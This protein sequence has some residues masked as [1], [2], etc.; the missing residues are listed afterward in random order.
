MGRK[1]PGKPRRP[2]NTAS[3]KPRKYTLQELQ[4]PGSAYEEWYDVRP[5]MD[6]SR[7]ADPRLSA[8]ALDL[9]RR[10]ARLGPS[11]GGK[12]PKAALYLDSLIDDGSLPIVG[13][14][15]TGIMVPIEEM[16]AR[17]GGASRDSIR[18][19]I[20]NLHTVGALLIET[21][22]DHDISYVRM[23]AK[24]PAEPGDPWHFEGDPDVV[25]ATTCI[26]NEIWEKL[27][28]DVA[29]AVSFMRTCRSQL[30]EPDPE[31]YG[32]HKSVNGPEHARQLFAAGE[33]SGFVD[34]KGCEACPT[35][36]LCTRSEDE[37]ES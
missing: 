6:A 16:A 19:S 27:P 18:E 3:S 13:S 35:G 24:R 10:M 28:L 5:G 14:D 34:Y 22:D 29:A 17:Q 9:M 12:I 21:D 2:R 4:P 15:G 30:R 23:V 26:P 37:P 11:Y 31:E 33:A 8:E 25:A 36:H 7:I 1:K 20:H 32:G